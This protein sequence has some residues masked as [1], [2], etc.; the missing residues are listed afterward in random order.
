MSSIE[1][2]RHVLLCHVVWATLVNV[3][4]VFGVRQNELYDIGENVG[5]ESLPRGDDVTVNVTLQTP[6]NL[7]GE[8]YNSIFVRQFWPISLSCVLR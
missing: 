7:F 1:H 5:D 2:L 4:F 6:I 3:N 8:S